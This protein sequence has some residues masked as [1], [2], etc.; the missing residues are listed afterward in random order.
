MNKLIKQAFTL[1]ELLVVIAIIGILS[2]MIVVSMSGVTQKATIAK[3]QVFSNSL[4]NSLMINLI[5]EYKLDGNGDDSWGTNHGIINGATSIPLGCVYNSCFNFD[6]N[7][8]VNLPHSSINVFSAPEYSQEFWINQT[9]SSGCLLSSHNSV[10]NWWHGF[11]ISGGLIQLTMQNGVENKWFVWTSTNAVVLTGRW[12]HIVVTWKRTGII[13]SDVKFYKDGVSIPLNASTSA[14]TYDNTFVP[15]YVLGDTVGTSIG[16]ING[17]TPSFYFAGLMD[18]IRIYN[19]AMSTFQ[20]QEQYY[21][22]L[23][24]LLANGQVSAE[25]YQENVFKLSQY[26]A[27][28]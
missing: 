16:R 1:I 19:A 21:T 8:F 20:I 2:G 6:G 4:R 22:G 12:T 5:A 23:N 3:A 28:K 15:K 24:K 17:D 14:G 7:D 25:E 26:S 13:A 9:S 10:G 27:N 11:C 18:N